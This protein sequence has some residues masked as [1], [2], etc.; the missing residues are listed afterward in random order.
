MS[1]WRV[2]WKCYRSRYRM[3]SATG[4]RVGSTTGEQRNFIEMDG[5]ETKKVK[6]MKRSALNGKLFPI[7]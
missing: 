4:Q 1:C 7:M 6:Q 3:T 2:N 5:C